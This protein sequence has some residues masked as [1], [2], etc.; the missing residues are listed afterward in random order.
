MKPNFLKRQ[1]KLRNILNE[2][3]LDAF[4]MTDANDIYYYT[5]CGGLD[6]D[7]FMIFDGESKPLLFL[8]LLENEV[9]S[10]HASII[11]IK[12]MN[13]IIKYLKIYKK[14]G[15]DEY[16]LVLHTFNIL[17][18]K[19]VNLVPSSKHIK[20]L[21]MIKDE[22]EIECIK[23]SLG[24]VK[25]V[26]DNTTI[27]GKTELELANEIDMKMRGFLSTNA[28][29]TIV[30]SGK[31]CAYVH[32]RPD[33]KHIKR[34]ENVIIDLGAKYNGYCSDV[35]RTAVSSDKMR[36]I[37]DDILEMQKDIMD[38]ISPGKTFMQVQKF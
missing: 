33:M 5:G 7:S 6:G 16:D 35:T 12:K 25:H 13:E 4:L 9:K 19:G 20:A 24:I 21:R 29:P 22:Y 27:V 23:K 31:N 11:F 32:H 38:F 36:K 10:K 28:F 17:K 26:L 15:F 14:V 34:G 37:Y 8:S 2:I 3:E 1:K 30:A 18:R